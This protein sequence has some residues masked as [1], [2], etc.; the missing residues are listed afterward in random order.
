MKFTEIMLSIVLALISLI[1]IANL[2]AY[3]F[4]LEEERRE[5]RKTRKAISYEIDGITYYGYDK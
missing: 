2:F 4:E 1:I 5:I 3:S